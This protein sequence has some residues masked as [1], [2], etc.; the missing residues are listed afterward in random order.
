MHLTEIDHVAIAVNDL[1]AAIEY[2]RQAFGAEV[3]HVNPTCGDE[4]TL[5]AQVTDGVV[6]DVS[7]ECLGCSISTAGA[8]VM[9]D[10]VTGLPVEEALR[11]YDLVLEMLQ[12]RGTVEGDPGLLGDTVA[13]AGVARFPARVKCALL[14]WAAMRDAVLTAATTK[15]PA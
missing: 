8:S 1:E 2:Y 7:Y 11:R 4:I 14:G 12:S 3:H 13:F 9:A 15:E 5:R 10:T 6:H